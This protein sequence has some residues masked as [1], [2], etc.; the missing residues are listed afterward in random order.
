MKKEFYKLSLVFIMIV[1][2]F[3][4]AFFLGREVTLSNQQ[5]SQ[6]QELSTSIEAKT[7]SSDNPSFSNSAPDEKKEYKKIL[8]HKQSKKKSKSYENRGSKQIEKKQK[9]NKFD[10]IYG[11]VIASYADKESASEKS[12]QLKL[13]FPNW[14]I[15]FKKSKDVYKVY[16]G[17]FRT[18]LA[19]EKI[20]KELQKKPDFSSIKLETI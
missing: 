5:Q 7:K 19:A 12:T 8:S 16:I 4:L 14:R 15:F 18:K 2:S 10:E 6:K 1:F 17:P 9:P 13:R 3:S 20:L 11:L